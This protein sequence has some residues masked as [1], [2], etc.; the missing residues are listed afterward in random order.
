[1]AKKQPVEVN[2]PVDVDTPVVV[3]NGKNA[4]ALA[5]D[6]N[7]ITDP[8][9][10][11]PYAAELM[12]QTCHQVNHPG[13]GYV[14]PDAMV[15]LDGTVYPPFNTVLITVLGTDS[16]IFALPKVTF[17]FLFGKAR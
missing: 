1:M 6:L 4:K 7:N 17:E 9:I 13:L 15:E 10:I 14:I 8:A 5:E 16:Q 3:D 11:D 2:V 12:W